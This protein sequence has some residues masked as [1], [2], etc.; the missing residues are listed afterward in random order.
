MMH[1]HTHM[2]VDRHTTH[3]EAHTSSSSKYTAT[4]GC[5]KGV[6]CN[7]VTQGATS[8]ELCYKK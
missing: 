4:H 2:H 8:H 1:G 6:T 7:K 5:K 3:T